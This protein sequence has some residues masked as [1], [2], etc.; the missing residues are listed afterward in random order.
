[1]E[2]M[3]KNEVLGGILLL[4]G[5]QPA[6]VLEAFQYPRPLVIGH[7]AAKTRPQ[8]AC[9]CMCDKLTTCKDV[10][11]CCFSRS[12]ASLLVT[13]L[14]AVSLEEAK[15]LSLQFNMCQT[16]DWNWRQQFSVFGQGTIEMGSY[17]W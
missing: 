16:G 6:K 17:W 10:G 8:G 12:Q 2:K 3:G 9:V 15:K 4:K 7:S 14:R 11:L 5:Q 13:M 1:M